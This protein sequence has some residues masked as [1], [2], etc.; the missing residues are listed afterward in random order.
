VNM[1]DDPLVSLGYCQERRDGGAIKRKADTIIH[2]QPGDGTVQ[3][4]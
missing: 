3:V 2:D 4:R 1:S